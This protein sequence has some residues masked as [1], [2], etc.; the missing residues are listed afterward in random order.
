M[1]L[2]ERGPVLSKPGW[3]RG[4]GTRV[5]SAGPAGCPACL[6]P[7]HPVGEAGVPTHV[8]GAGPHAARGTDTGQVR[9]TAVYQSHLHTT[10]GGGHPAGS[11]RL[12]SRRNKPALW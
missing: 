4:P 2:R 1:R 12:G 3:I 11:P 9:S 6:P 10:R 7:L 5:C 8:Y